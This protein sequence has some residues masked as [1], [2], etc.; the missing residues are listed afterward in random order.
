[1]NSDN[2]VKNYKYYLDGLR[3]FAAFLVVFTH[4][5]GNVLQKAS[6]NDFSVS[7]NILWCMWGLAA[8]AVP[9]FLMITGVNFIGGGKSI[10]KHTKRLLI[11]YVAWMVI[12]FCFFITLSIHYGWIDR[13][14]VDTVYSRLITLPDYAYHL[15]YLPLAISICLLNPVLEQCRENYKYFIKIFTLFLALSMLSSI[16]KEFDLFY[17]SNNIINPVRCLFP[18][19]ILYFISGYYFD[20]S[21]RSR[22]AGKSIILS[23]L[24]IAAYVA[25]SVYCRIYKISSIPLFL[26]VRDSLVGFIFSSLVFNLFKT[27]YSKL[28]KFVISILNHCSRHTLCIYLI[29]LLFVN[30]AIA[31]IDKFNGYNP[32]LFSICASIIVFLVSY[33]ISIIIKKVRLLAYIV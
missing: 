14:S 28:P 23:I 10:A 1:M 9:L 5:S 15:W 7:N 18:I 12:Y 29:H 17:I 25:C 21:M 32:I 16:I 8:I 20:R 24:F 4:I 3:V 30:Y 22:V 27:T 2:S 19:F 33:A 31:Q 6:P 11:I 26:A 13:I